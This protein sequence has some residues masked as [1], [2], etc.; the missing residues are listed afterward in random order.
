MP[1]RRIR[2]KIDN[3][4][5]AQLMKQFKFK[6]KSAIE[7]RF[8]LLCS[9]IEMGAKTIA[10][11][12]RKQE[13]QKI[14]RDG[15]K[16][17]FNDVETGKVIL[18][19]QRKKNK[20]KKKKIDREALKKEQEHTALLKEKEDTFNANVSWAME[21]TKKYREDIKRFNLHKNSVFVYFFLFFFIYFKHL[22]CQTNDFITVK[23][24]TR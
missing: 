13:T 15:L 7:E 18:K 5:S 12:K 10:D 23:E 19:S 24:V 8:R 11:V 16:K 3:S 2:Q 21:T 4:S 17:L 6:T 20:K 14:E 1:S 22:Q 9:K